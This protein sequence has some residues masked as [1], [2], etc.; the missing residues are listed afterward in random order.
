MTRWFRLGPWWILTALMVL[1]LFR[2]LVTM[3][4]RNGSHLPGHGP[5]IIA[6]NHYSEI[7]PVVMGVAVWRL[8]RTP[9]FLAKASLFKSRSSASTCAARAKSRSSAKQQSHNSPGCRPPPD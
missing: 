2:L 6:P 4:V 3:K 7:D 8:G 1:P 9:R 5:F